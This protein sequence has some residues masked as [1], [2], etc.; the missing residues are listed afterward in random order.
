MRV[1]ISYTTPVHLTH[2][3]RNVWHDVTLTILDPRP[4]SEP[5]PQY[6]ASWLCDDG[7]HNITTDDDDGQ[8][9]SG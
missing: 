2:P 8:A 6:P 1:Q 7:G 5:F 3:R 9:L 4:L